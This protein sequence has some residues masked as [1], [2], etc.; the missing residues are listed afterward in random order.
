MNHDQ[1]LQSLAFFRLEYA[2]DQVKYWLM[3]PDIEHFVFDFYFPATEDP[4][5]PIYLCCFAQNSQGGFLNP[6]NPDVLAPYPGEVL[7]LGGPLK[8]TGSLVAAADMQQLLAGTSPDDNYLLF[9]PTVD[10]HGQ[11]YYG[12][13]PFQRTAT[14]DVFG[15]GGINTNPSPP[16]TAMVA[17]ELN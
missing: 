2:I 7:M 17:T 11:V 4:N 3:Q 12:I 6:Y 1:N 9:A 10:E 16:A 15:S 8:L 13:K 5:R 14:G